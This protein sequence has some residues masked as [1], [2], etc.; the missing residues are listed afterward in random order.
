[1][2]QN[3]RKEQLEK[4]EALRNIAHALSLT[5]WSLKSIFTA[6]DTYTPVKNCDE[7]SVAKETKNKKSVGQ[8]LKLPYFKKNSAWINKT[9]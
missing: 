7:E 8:L 4:K 5:H 3:S 9:E 1:M 6:S 2:S